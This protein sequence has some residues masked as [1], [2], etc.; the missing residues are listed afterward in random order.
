MK[1]NQKKLDDG[2]I[3]LEVTAT[4]KEVD[5]AYGEAQF[6]FAQ[7]MNL[8]LE[9]GK[10][11]AQ[12]AKE[13][14]GIEN[15]DAVVVP[16]V[17]EHLIPFALDKKNLVPAFLPQVNPDR[18]PKRGESYSFAFDITPK[19]EY[20]LTSYEPV[21]ITIPPMKVDES[22]IET[23]IAQMAE[24]YAEY[25]ADDP[26]PVK[27]GDTILISMSGI[28][29]EKGEPIEALSIDSRSYIVGEGY[30]PPSFDEGVLDMQVGE[31]K[32]FSFTGPTI[33]SAGGSTEQIVECTVTVSEIQKKVIPAITDE[34]MSKNMPLFGSVKKL[35][36][37]IRA[38]ME[39]ARRGEYEIFKRQMAAAELAERFEGKIEDALYEAMRDTL[40]NN[41]NAQ[42]AR[43]GISREQFITQNGGEQQFGMM[44]MMEARRNLV[45]GFALDALFRH[46]KLEV[47]DDDILDACRTID[48]QQ[49]ERMKEQMLKSGY[50][51]ALHESAS[52]IKAN[53]WLVEQ[54]NISIQES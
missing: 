53:K 16:Q 19:P 2:R 22:E 29:K 39:D 50:G 18:E 37:A 14:L 23:Q 36:G 47:S 44:L 52:R 17:V 24:S 49:P 27:T 13:K 15:L 9:Q 51:Y 54:A 10:T 4:D 41:L 3:R 30:M 12:A 5:A 42:L 34:W 46:E 25:V 6:A 31:T 45:E 8:P 28:D 32:T 43:Q 1:V 40:N 33:D 38:Q 7:Q 35:R 20:E 26:R 21:S 11:I 48:P